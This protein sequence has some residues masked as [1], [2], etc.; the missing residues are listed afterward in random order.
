MVTRAEQRA[1]TR[2]HIVEAATQTFSERGFHGASTR[3][4]ASRAGVNQ[5]LITH[6]FGTKDAL[7]RE[8]MGRVFDALTEAL[9]HRRRQSSE[10]DPREQA[11]A[12]TREFVRFAATNP[13]LF[14]LMLDEGK[15]DDERLRWLVD[16]HLRPAYER[17]LELGDTMGFGKDRTMATHYYYTLAGAASLMFVVGAEC[18]RLTGVDPST[19]ETIERH[20]EFVA[21]LLVP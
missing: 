18:E 12:L 20:A 15:V 16:T 1:Q 13:T 21:R 4:I 14:R 5:G 9:D 19:E 2:Q 10:D 8:A 3:D 6:H 11:R 17:F 7:W